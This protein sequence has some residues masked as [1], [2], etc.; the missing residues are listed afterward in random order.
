MLK[1]RSYYIYD[2]ETESIR[3]AD[4]PDHDAA[5]DLYALM[6]E[7]RFEHD[8]DRWAFDIALDCVRNMTDEECERI[9]RDG[10]IPDF[11][12]GYGMEVRNKYIYPSEL[13]PYEEADDVSS[14]VEECVY[15]I[16]TSQVARMYSSYLQECRFYMVNKFMDELTHITK[17]K[18]DILF[19][20]LEKAK[21][22]NIS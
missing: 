7:N 9:Q 4:G 21:F 14:A 15:A 19:L 3:V 8:V 12:F 10:K 5:C 20:A 2:F 1:Y 22:L 11:H 16:L 18:A 17:L 6:T 13:H